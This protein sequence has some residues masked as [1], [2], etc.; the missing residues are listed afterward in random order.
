MG[1][2]HTSDEILAGAVAVAFE[3]GLSRL[4]FGRVAKHLGIPDRTVVYYFPSSE[5]L[6]GAVLEAIGG[7]LQVALAPAFV[8]PAADHVA[9]FRAAWPVL[10]QPES[11]RVFALFFEAS[12]LAAAGREPF[13]TL[14]PRL[15]T[16][17]VDWVGSL[18]AAPVERRRAEAEAA[19][20]VIDGLLLLRQ[21]GG[22]EAADRAAA[23]ILREHPDEAH[24]PPDR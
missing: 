20:G 16:A 21:L 13:R 11:D 8:A 2:R 18:I 19:I 23:A 5:A 1:Y 3:D 17:W 6:V 12:G 4:T 24:R 15:V 7:Q 14:V 10:A 22:P 9:L